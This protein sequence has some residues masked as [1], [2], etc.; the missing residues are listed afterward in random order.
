MV[1]SDTGP[2]EIAG[3]LEDMDVLRDLKS[4][5]VVHVEVESYN[6]NDSTGRI[7]DPLAPDIGRTAD[8]NDLP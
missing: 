8:V 7:L 3:L 5:D 4:F 2:G 6:S 1:S